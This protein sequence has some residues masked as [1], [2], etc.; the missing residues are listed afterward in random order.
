MYNAISVVIFHLSW[1]VQSDVWGTISDRGVVT[2]IT[3]GN[4]EF[5]YY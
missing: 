5:H 4:S 3:G 2:H 1:K